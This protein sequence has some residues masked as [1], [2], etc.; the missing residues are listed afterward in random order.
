[1]S[2]RDRS[3]TTQGDVRA[4]TWLTRLADYT[5]TRHRTLQRITHVADSSLLQY[6][7]IHLRDSSGQGGTLLLTAITCYHH[8]GKNLLIFAHGYADRLT[9]ELDFL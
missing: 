3:T 6:L 8:L 9:L 2:T 1:M 7:V 5:E 4:C